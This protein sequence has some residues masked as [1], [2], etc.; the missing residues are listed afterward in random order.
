MLGTIH[1]SLYWYLALPTCTEPWLN[2]LS[3]CLRHLISTSDIVPI[4]IVL[5]TDRAE[6]REQTCIIRARCAAPRGDLHPDKRAR[7]WSCSE[8][9]HAC[10]GRLLPAQSRERGDR[11]GPVWET[12]CQPICLTHHRH[13][14]TGWKIRANTNSF[15]S[16]VMQWCAGFTESYFSS[17]S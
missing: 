11:K 1:H 7:G 16:R 9:A 12:M 15:L 5:C 8:A 14:T 6:P 3:I 13:V 4:L 2:G 10:N 17:C